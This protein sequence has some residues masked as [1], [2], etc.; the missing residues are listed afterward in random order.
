MKIFRYL[1]L[2]IVFVGAPFVTPRLVAF[3]NMA[4]G[5]VFEDINQDGFQDAGEAGLAGTLVTDGYDIAKTDTEGRFSFTLHEN[6]R[7]VYLHRPA[8]YKSTGSFYKATGSSAAYHFGLTAKPK[9]KTFSFVHISDTETYEF[10]DWLNIVKDYTRDQ[11]PAFIMH[12]G[13]ICYKRGLRFHADHVSSQALGADVH[14]AIGNHDLVAGP[15]GEKMYENLFGP[16]YYSFEEGNVLFVSTP[17]LSGDHRPSYT[18]AQVYHWLK[19]LFSMLPKEQPKV[20]YNHDLLSYK[21]TLDYGISESENLN[22][23]EYNVKAWV[24]GHWHN[25]HI[26]RHGKSGI[27]SIGTGPVPKGG[28]DHSPSCFRVITID[29][30]GNISTELRYTSVNRHINIITPNP[31]QLVYT[32]DNSLLVS[33]N[34][35]H[36]ASPTD[37]VRVDVRPAG[38]T[39]SW[40]DLDEK[41]TWQGMKAQT[42]WNWTYSWPLQ[43]MEPGRYV[44]E[45]EAFL[46]NGR[47]TRKREEFDLEP[48]SRSR[49]LKT[50]SDWPNLAFDAAHASFHAHE[51]GL[52]LRL[53]WLQNTGANIFMSSPIVGNG[54]VYVAAIDNSNYKNCFVVAYDGTTG[55]EIWRY[56]TG[57]SVKN[58]ITFTQ[59]KVFATDAEGI[60]YALDGSNGSLAWKKDLGISGL[61]AFVS[62]MASEGNMVY[63]GIKKG[64]SA[65]DANTG[66]FTWRNTHNDS[67]EGTVSTLTVGPKMLIA[68]AHWNALFGHDK[69]T[70]ERLW[71]R[72]DDGLRFRDGSATIKDGKLF[73]AARKKIFILDPATGKTLN[74]SETGFSHA[75]NTTPLVTEDLVIV[76][77]ADKGLAAFDRSTLK[78]AWN[79][80]T[81]RALVFTAP[82]TQTEERTV[83]TSP[84][85]VGNTV[86]FGASDGFFYALDVNSGKEKWKFELGAPILTS[87]AI[88]GDM[89]YIAD[90]SG[91]V[92]AFSSKQVN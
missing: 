78:E 3:Q 89:L 23:N 59:G 54:I 4:K 32:E 17:M 21:D 43:K 69:K 62:G 52:P 83:E 13:D 64:L 37:S 63:T 76:G 67:G 30:A 19:K 8:N 24:Y 75:A 77:T 80:P 50:G 38:K 70:G 28:I 11:D 91:N 25:N 46:E 58:T 18:K 29:E 33:V 16:V 56:R 10:R 27:L 48:K 57:S 90:F 61:P 85:R 1:F 47:M 34:A 20:M 51:P 6:A 22:L 35:Y 31:G 72:K 60:T 2:G 86:Y 84:V 26:H 74:S 79:Y 41:E 92:Y 39:P 82:Y 45:V 12:T 81:G 68:S 87:P 73:I 42:D 49:V 36:S 44:V 9:K 40:H 88:S 53:Q 14:Y 55:E 65:L 15:Y 7:F 66:K 5:V 71:T